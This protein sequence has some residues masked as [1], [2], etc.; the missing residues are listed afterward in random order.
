MSQQMRAMVIHEF[1]LPNVFRAE[2]I[3][4]PEVLPGHVLIRVAATSVNPL[5]YKIRRYGSAIPFSP[6]LPAVLHG[7]V[8]GVVEAVGA[9]VTAFRPGDEVYAF[10]GGVKGL[11]G[12]LAEYLLADA[13]LVASKPVSLSLAQAAA[14]PEAAITAWDGLMERAK[15]QAGQTVL[16]HGAT[17]GVAHLAIQIA[18][19]AGAR[20][21]A[22]AS[23]D[24]KM[25]IACELGAEGA[26]NYHTQSVAAY[27]TAYTGG[28]GFDVVF[29]SVGSANLARSC[30][31][32]AVGG[33]VISVAAAT[34][35]IG[36]LYQKTLSLHAILILL[37]LLSGIGR[38]THGRILRDLARLV[39]AGKIRPLIDPHTFA[40]REVADAHQFLEAGQALGK[41][42][43]VND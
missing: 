30:E 1:G 33:T 13:D 41:V 9:Q 17:G 6:L 39:D 42:V 27:V 14:L 11:G 19:A 38:A 40:F 12:A 8:A 20:V 23:S 21:F 43:L 26:I 18:K 37:P 25:R 35:D 15:V 28:K 32:A 5:D 24:E 31:A 36:L 10:A 22:T 7:D 3:P 29:D 16:V 2:M 4:Q 34:L